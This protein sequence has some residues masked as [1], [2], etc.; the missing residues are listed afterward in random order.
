MTSMNR[1]GNLPKLPAL[2]LGVLMALALAG[3]PGITKPLEKP[4]VEL[5]GVSVTSV[6]LSGIDARL[7]FS[8]TNPNTVG[9]PL[10][11]I[12]WELAIGGASAFR[13][14]ATLSH[15]IPA[16]GSAPVDVDVHI[17][18][19]AA[20]DMAARLSHGA[21]DYHLAGTLHFETGLGGIA[22]SLDTTGT[23]TDAL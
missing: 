13:G 2:A 14:R 23:L 19:A 16:R 4:V 11:A 5:R 18:A 21:R 20:V 12:D 15:D 8:I 3:C 22:V 1:S 6:S 10:R 9:L 17:G 7:A